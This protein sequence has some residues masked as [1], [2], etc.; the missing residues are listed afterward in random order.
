M[1]PDYTDILRAY[2]DTVQPIYALEKYLPPIVEDMP[3][4]TEMN[5]EMLI[6]ELL[7]FN[8]ND[9]LCQEEG[10]I[11]CMDFLPKAAEWFDGNSEN[12]ATI[13]HDK[14][15]YYIQIKNPY[16]NELV[17]ILIPSAKTKGMVG[18]GKHMFRHVLSSRASSTEEYK[19]EAL[20]TM[21]SWLLSEERTDDCWLVA[22]EGFLKDYSNKMARNFAKGQR[23]AA[24]RKYGE[25]FQQRTNARIKEILASG[26]NRN[27]CENAAKLMA[28][29]NKRYMM[30]DRGKAM[31][32][33][34][35]NR[36]KKKYKVA[37][38]RNTQSLWWVYVETEEGD[39]AMYIPLAGGKDM[40][41]M[42]MHRV[43][44]EIARYEMFQNKGQKVMESDTHWLVAEEGIF[45]DTAKIFERKRYMIEVWEQMSI[46]E[47]F[48]FTMTFL[49]MA[50][51]NMLTD[52]VE[53][54]RD[55]TKGPI[56]EEICEWAIHSSTY[57]K[58]AYRNRIRR[59][60][61]GDFHAIG[62]FTT[63]KLRD[64]VTRDTGT[65]Y[66][67]SSSL[68]GINVTQLDEPSFWAERLRRNDSVGQF[69][70]SF[71][72]VDL[73]IGR[74]NENKQFKDLFYKVAKIY[75]LDINRW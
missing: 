52:L 2:S 40:E 71:V 23:K 51:E 10:K 39:S 74:M 25:D 55:F 66:L 24:E 20:K 60:D 12:E 11:R 15:L 64:G 49:N 19:K 61:E 47:Q 44:N 75:H 7:K 65:L 8:F 67:P 17:G 18:I 14:N 21:E 63:V 57:L 16:T 22:E 36:M 68:E 37:E 43:A 42:A 54:S 9:Y 29:N 26:N 5:D 46:D 35:C 56:A 4:I 59:Y 73:P 48:L 41:R 3:M 70:Y 27:I 31:A 30:G 28:K 50:P 13:Q 33:A 53:V 1:V 6:Q 69:H 38:L 45:S 34:N 72:E 58:Q 62:T 32:E